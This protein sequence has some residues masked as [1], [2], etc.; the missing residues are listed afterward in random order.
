V[1]DLNDPSPVEIPGTSGIG[2]HPMAFRAL[3]ESRV[4]LSL[5]WAEGATSIQIEPVEDHLEDFNEIV[6]EYRR[7]ATKGESN[8][9]HA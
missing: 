3:I 6:A 8:E 1:R 9:G 4:A 2:I 7:R 5:V